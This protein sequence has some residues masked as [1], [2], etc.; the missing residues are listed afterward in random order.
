M[1]VYQGLCLK[2]TAVPNGPDDAFW[3]RRGKEYTV[4][5][6]KDGQRFVFTKYWFWI[7]ASLFDVENS[8]E[9]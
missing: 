5:K 4:S 7:D 1:K 8:E 9:S 6:E 2:D 3:L